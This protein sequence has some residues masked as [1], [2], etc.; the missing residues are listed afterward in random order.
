MECFE[1]TYRPSFKI[2]DHE[3]VREERNVGR[4]GYLFFGAPN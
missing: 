3:L 4:P 1:R 2:R